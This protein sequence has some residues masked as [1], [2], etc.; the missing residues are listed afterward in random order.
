MTYEYPLIEGFQWNALQKI[1][2]SL[3]IP[4]SEISIS[5]TE[6]KTYM[7]FMREL[8][9]E[10]KAILDGIMSSNPCAPVTDKGTTFRVVDIWGMRKW[11]TD[12]LGITPTY[13]FET[14]NLDGSG[15]CFMYL[16]FPRELTASEKQRIIDTYCSLMKEL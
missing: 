10:E 11:V 12:Q 1:S 9:D 8:S 2:L 15:E 6:D 5:S 16:S 7:G 4:Q 13:W 14:E 3:N